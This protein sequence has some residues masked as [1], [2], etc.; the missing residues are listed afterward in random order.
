VEED[1]EEWEIEED[2]SVKTPEEKELDREED[3]AEP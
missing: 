2:Y 1:R 3:E